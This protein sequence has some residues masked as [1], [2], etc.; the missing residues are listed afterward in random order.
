V[1]LDGANH[2]LQGGEPALDQFIDA[3]SAFWRSLNDRRRLAR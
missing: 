3:M 2:I 1:A